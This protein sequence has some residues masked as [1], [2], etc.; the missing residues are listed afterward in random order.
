MPL[1][2][3]ASIRRV[4]IVAGAILVGLGT[5]ACGRVAHPTS[6]D[7]EGVYVDAGPL[8]YQVQISRQ[9]NPFNVEDKEYL[10]GVTAPPPKPDEEWFAVFLWATNETHLDHTTTNSFAIV[11]TQGNRYYPISVN[12]A[13]NPYAW[14]AQTLR[15]R[16]TE[17]APDSTAYFGPT[18]GSL[19]LFKLNNSVYSN[20]PLRLE[21]NAPGQSRPSS[22]SL[23]L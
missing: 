17:P 5:A 12:P 1:R 11:D 4:S 13:V 2:L 3:P 22:V 7:S 23:D 8:T 18:Q 15:P 19:L 6:A 21:I 9:L 10:K 14:T 20:R 16:G